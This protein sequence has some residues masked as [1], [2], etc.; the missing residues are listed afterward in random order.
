MYGTCTE[1]RV[2]GAEGQK[3]LYEMG[4]MCMSQK[5]GTHKGWIMDV[6][7]VRMYV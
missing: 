2:K 5:H 1:R 3:K 6:E 4:T 7:G